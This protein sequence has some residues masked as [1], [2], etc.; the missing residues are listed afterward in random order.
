MSAIVDA[1]TSSKFRCRTDG[2]ETDH[3]TVVRRRILGVVECPLGC[4]GDERRFDTF[5]GD[6]R[7]VEEDECFSL[8]VSFCARRFAGDW[9]LAGTS[10]SV[11]VRPR[12][13]GEGATTL[14]LRA[15]IPC[16]WRSLRFYIASDQWPQL[17]KWNVVHTHGNRTG[18][19]RRPAASVVK[20]SAPSDISNSR[21]LPARFRENRSLDHRAPGQRRPT[22][23]RCG[24]HLSQPELLDGCSA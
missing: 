2:S 24:P 5:G 14:I 20:M 23:S 12:D 17:I 9:R 3:C 13:L 7:S 4:T 1:I 11:M 22:R 10:S 21:K 6:L 18:R 19:S 8:L 15:E 16:K